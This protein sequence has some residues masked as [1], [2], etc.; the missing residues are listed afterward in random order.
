MLLYKFLKL[1]PTN[2]I[3]KD[4]FILPQFGLYVLIPKFY[5][6]SAII[7]HVFKNVRTN[8]SPSFFKNVVKKS[9]YYNIF[10]IISTSNVCK[11]DFTYTLLYLN[12]IKKNWFISHDLLVIISKKTFKLLH[13][14]KKKLNLG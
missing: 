8:N 5:K 1:G 13:L 12:K 4:L 7:K 3:K 6:I 9:V 14:F 10:L 2:K 11:K